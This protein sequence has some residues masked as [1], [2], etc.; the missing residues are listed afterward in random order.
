MR[1]E[2]F[3]VQMWKITVEKNLNWGSECMCLRMATRLREPGT[4]IPVLAT[5]AVERQRQGRAGRHG[6]DDDSECINCRDNGKLCPVQMS[7]AARRELRSVSEYR[8][9]K[10]AIKIA[11]CCHHRDEATGGSAPVCG[12]GR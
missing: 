7:A 8:P 12:R 5:P 2:Q 6:K 1:P 3:Y 10:V 9:V 11:E 4:L